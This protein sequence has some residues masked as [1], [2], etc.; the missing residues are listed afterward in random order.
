MKVTPEN[1][2]QIQ[3]YL[4]Q[5]GLTTAEVRSDILDHICTMLEHESD[6]VD[7]TLANELIAA[8]FP[9]HVIRQL[10]ADTLY[11]L[12]LKSKVTMLKL[13][14]VTGYMAICLLVLGSYFS[15]HP[16]NSE[17]LWYSAPYLS[18]VGIVIFCFSFLPALFMYSYQ[19]FLEQVKQ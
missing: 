4:T 12:T 18:V 5:H 15:S 7:F 14:F 6:I 2:D 10:Q 13:I 1:I 8:E 3:S 19:R 16:L 17:F 11:Y 9:P